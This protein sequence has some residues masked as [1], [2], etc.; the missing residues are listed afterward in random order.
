MGLRKLDEGVYLYPGSP[1]TLIKVLDDEAVIIDPGHGGGRH[2]DLKREIRKLGVKLKAQLATHGHADHV[3]VAPRLDAPLF[4]HRFE[5]S[6]A[7][8]PLN[9]ELLTFGSKA[10]R[11]FL[12]FQF[13]E[14]VRVHAVFEWGDELF[15]METIQLSG[16]SPGMTGFVD[17]ENSLLYA[18]DSFFGERVINSVGLPYL[19]D[20]GL[21]KA[22]IKELQNYAENGYLLIPSHGKPVK[23]EE[24]LNLL[25]FNLARVEETESLILEF[26][27]KPMSMAELAFRVMKHYGVEATPQKLALNL[28]PVRAFIAELYNEGKIE[29]L[30]DNGLRWKIRR[31]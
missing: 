27:E 17:N 11:G 22:S 23:G 31:D 29:A 1:G 15:G 12:V 2:K 19:V 30:V 16:H 26:L 8:S 7:E 18:G 24:A 25:N 20:L 28:V 4:M 10:P 21:Y 13:P 9:R 14:E 6:I 3:A 5:F